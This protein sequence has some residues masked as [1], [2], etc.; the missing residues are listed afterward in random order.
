MCRVSV[1]LLFNAGQNQ[2]LSARARNQLI[3]R[4]QIL[5]RATSYSSATAPPF[6]FLRQ[7]S[8]KFCIIS[9]N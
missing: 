9:D 3:Q 8:D 5:K 1:S 6:L 7:V 4:R 2:L